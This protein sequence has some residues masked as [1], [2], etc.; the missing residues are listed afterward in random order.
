MDLGKSREYLAKAVKLRDESWGAA[1]EML[2]GS[3]GGSTFGS[4]GGG[5]VEGSPTQERVG[6][7]VE[8]A[9]F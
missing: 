5:G 1:E 9:M 4:F 8:E 7:W 2:Y 6:V 3:G